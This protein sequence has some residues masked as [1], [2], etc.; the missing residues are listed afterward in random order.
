MTAYIGL[1]AKDFARLADQRN[2]ELIVMPDSA[3]GFKT[4]S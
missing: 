1:L 2:I 3:D 4:C